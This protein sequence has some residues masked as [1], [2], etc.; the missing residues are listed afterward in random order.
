MS[1]MNSTIKQI[2]E[3]FQVGGQTI[4][5]SFLRYEGKATT[6]ITYQSVHIEETYSTNDE[7]EYYVEHYDFDIYSKGDYFEIIDALKD[8]LQEHGF[9]WQP[10]YSSED[11]YEDETGYYHKTLNFSFIRYEGGRN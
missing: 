3:G 2:F 5:V 7:L 1:S 8:R 10:T 6:Y 4:P 11:M 9:T